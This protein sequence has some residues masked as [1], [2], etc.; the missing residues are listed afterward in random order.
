MQLS[1]KDREKITSTIERIEDEITKL[2]DELKEL[3]ELHQFAWNQYGSELCGSEMKSEEDALASKIKKKEDVV[4]LL[5]RV[6]VETFDISWERLR[7]LKEELENREVK[8]K[9]AQEYQVRLE[10][11]VATIREARELTGVT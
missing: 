4:F 8:I 5:E 10:N 3:K 11:L 9:K 6:L 1:V 7:D 2:K